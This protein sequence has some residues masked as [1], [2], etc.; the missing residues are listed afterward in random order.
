M[1]KSYETD[2]ACDWF[3][4]FDFDGMEYTVKKQGNPG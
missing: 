3:D 2:A 1:I 4:H